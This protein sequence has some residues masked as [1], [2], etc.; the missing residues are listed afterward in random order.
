[1]ANLAS[2]SYMLDGGY[3]ADVPLV[4]AAIDPCFSCTDRSISIK[5]IDRGNEGSMDWEKLRTYSI[6]WYKNHGFDAHKI[7]LSC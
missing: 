2:I 5:Q 6:E 1:M 3:L 4:I 7:K